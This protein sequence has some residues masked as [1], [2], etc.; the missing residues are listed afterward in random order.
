MLMYMHYKGGHIYK[1][2][3]WHNT[4]NILDLHK[5]FVIIYKLSTSEYGKIDFIWCSNI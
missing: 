1:K 2:A 3:P 4:T 5:L